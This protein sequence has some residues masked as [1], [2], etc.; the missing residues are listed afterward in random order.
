MLR[1]WVEQRL[2]FLA[3][4]FYRR[5]GLTL[6]F[7]GLVILGLGSGL[8]WLK[9]DTSTKGLLR[10]DDPTILTYEKFADQFGREDLIVVGVEAGEV[11][12]PVFLEKLKALHRDLTRD[13]PLVVDVISLLNVRSTRGEGD[14]LVVEDFLKEVPAD[15]ARMADLKRRALADP[16]Y[17]NLYLSEDG[18]LTAVLVALETYSQIGVAEVGG[19][20]EETLT[21]FGEQ[22]QEDPA[23]RE[24]AARPELLT[25]EENRVAVQAI[26]AV[27][28]RHR[29]AGFQPVLAGSRVVSETLKRLMIKDIVVFLIIAVV[30][31]SLVLF[32]MFRRLAGVGLPLLVVFLGMTSTL[33]LMSLCRESIKIPTMILPSFLLAVGLGGAVHILALFFREYDH[34]GDK[35]EAIVQATGHSGLA[36][37]MTSLTTAAGLASFTTAEVAPIVSLGLFAGL[38]VLLTLAYTL[39]LLPALVGL[40]PLAGREEPSG[41]GKLPGFTRILDAVTDFSTAHARAITAAGL[42]LVA[43]SVA[44]ATRIHFTHDVLAWLDRSVEVRRATEKL[45]QE[46]KGTVVLE[47]IL[48]TGRE[49]G[50]HDPVFLHKLDRLTGELEGARWG[51]L[52]VGKAVSLITVLKEIHRALNEDRPEFYAV[53]D[54]PRLVAQEFLLFENTGSDDL[55]ELVDSTF[56]KARLSIRVPWRDT[57]EYVP[58][59]ADVER[60]VEHTFGNAVELTAT[61]M[62]TLFARTFNGAIRSALKSYVVALVVITLMMIILIGHLRLGLLSMLPNLTP[63]LMTAGVMGWFDLPF[64]ISTMLTFS[65]AIGLAVDDTIH[66]MHNYIRYYSQTGEVRQAVRL[67]LRTAGRAMLVTS[68]VLSL[69]FFIFM[70][71]SINNV[72]YFGFLTGLAVVLALL[73]DFLMAPA[74]M[75][76][77][78]GQKDKANGPASPS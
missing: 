71:A 6:F 3:G 55:E 30:V 47:L 54:D 65:V 38:G 46:L 37:I 50:L 61:G 53:P 7:M 64:D 77:I 13:V 5:R 24:A 52:F 18:R 59:L 9:V 25:E 17:R 2:M 51:D 45:D 67:T 44:G 27:L 60:R 12:D 68:V 33:G 74:L 40:L 23:G 41:S 34:H 16:F 73:A 1:D 22:T 49:N 10:P 62:M 19:G 11:F 39:I 21:G 48:D 20:V 28:D 15:P 72:F 4:V 32:L 31:M 42:V 57:M 56:R 29:S 69:G 43:V 8:F 63:I 70:L 35:Q 58:F 26:R 36:V 75:V 78:Y 14:R 66:F 76:L